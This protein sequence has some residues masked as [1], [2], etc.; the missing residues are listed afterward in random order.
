M[1]NIFKSTG[2]RTDPE[3]LNW[4]LVL[5]LLT[6]FLTF[7]LMYQINSDNMLIIRHLTILK[8]KIKWVWLCCII[9]RKIYLGN[10]NFVTQKILAISSNKYKHSN[11]TNWL[12][13]HLVKTVTISMLTCQQGYNNSVGWIWV[14]TSNLEVIHIS[15]IKCSFHVLTGILKT[16]F[17][18]SSICLLGFL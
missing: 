18:I 1:I 13:A 11:L 7:Q 5:C 15:N 10:H 2:P 4:M 3:F 14:H 6:S 12:E 9:C 8:I 17:F 16:R